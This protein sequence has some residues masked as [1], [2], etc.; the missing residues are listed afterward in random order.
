MSFNKLFSYAQA[1]MPNRSTHDLSHKNLFTAPCGTLVPSFMDFLI[2]GDIVDV[3]TKMHVQLPPMATDFYGRINLR[4]ELFYV[5]ARTIFGGWKQLITYPEDGVQGPAPDD[6]NYHTKYFPGAS[7]SAIPYG[8]YKNNSISVSFTDSSI[9]SAITTFEDYINSAANSADFS[10]WFDEVDDSNSF[11]VGAGTLS[12][13]LGLKIYGKSADSDF[14]LQN[15]FK[16]FQVGPIDS[17]IIL[18]ALNDGDT[19]IALYVEDDAFVYKSFPTPTEFEQSMLSTKH[20]LLVFIYGLYGETL[21]SMF[22]PFISLPELAYSMGEV[23]INNILPFVAY[24]KIYDDWYRDARIQKPLFPT[25]IYNAGTAASTHLSTIPYITHLSTGFAKKIYS[26]DQLKFY[27]GKSLFDLRQRLWQK[28]YFTT[29][30]A[31][32]QAGD[33]AKVEMQIDENGATSFTIAALREANALQQWAERNNLVD[34]RYGDIHYAQYGEYPDDAITDRS[35]YLGSC[36][37]EIYNKSVFQQAQYDGNSSNPFN[38]IGSKYASPVGV[39][40]STNLCNNYHVKEHGFLIALTSLVPQAYYSTGARRMFNYDTIADVAFPLLQGVGDQE[41]YAREIVNVY[42]GTGDDTVIGYQSR[43][44]EYKFIEDQVHGLLRDGESLD[45]FALQRSFT[46]APE[47]GT[48]FLEIPREYLDQVAATDY[49]V[50][51][52]GCWIDSFWSYRKSS[53][54]SELNA[55]PTLGRMRDVSTI[56]VVKAGRRL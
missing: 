50:S 9:Q 29:M 47:L 51:D 10:N 6:P 11:S 32:P 16:K 7:F 42:G 14:K 44:A 24:H 22:M 45:A 30:T 34:P 5:P 31:Q 33:P 8:D 3:S 2:P 36:T 38:A 43:Y 46:E 1:D 17:N 40:D 37:T 25:G 39:S 56:N 48:E 26:G 55:I 21:V 28:D 35:I 18:E 4:T 54:L 23:T 12:D 27:D 13:Y 41:V 49:K 53:R 15:A 20:D 52:Y 19:V